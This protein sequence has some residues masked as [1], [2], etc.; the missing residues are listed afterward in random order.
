MMSYKDNYFFLNINFLTAV[1]LAIEIDSG[2][3]FRSN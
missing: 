2:L 1:F 3:L